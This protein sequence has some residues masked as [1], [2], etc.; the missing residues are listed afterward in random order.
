M[1]R[2]DAWNAIS[3]R[4]RKLLMPAHHSRPRRRRRRGSIPQ[5]PDRRAR[6]QMR[7]GTSA[8]GSIATERL[9][10]PGQGRPSS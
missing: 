3:S 9:A 1:G 6:S 2:M 7:P 4:E 8:L 10:A 5:S